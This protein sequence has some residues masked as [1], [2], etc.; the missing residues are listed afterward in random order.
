MKPQQVTLKSKEL[1]SEMASSYLNTKNGN[2]S[3]VDFQGSCYFYKELCP[4][5][6]FHILKSPSLKMADITYNDLL[7]FRDVLI[8]LPRR[9]IQ[10]YKC[11]K[12]NALMKNSDSIPSKDR[13]SANTVNKYIQRLRAL[14][15][16]A[17]NLGIINNNLAKSLKLVATDVDKLQRLPLTQEEISTLLSSVSQ[18][19]RYLLQVLTLTGM[20]LSELYKCEVEELEG[21]KCFSLLNRDIKLK[22]KSSYRVIPVHRGLLNRLEDFEH[23][24]NQVSSDNLAKTT[25]ATIKRLNFKR[26]E[27]KFLYSLRHTFATELIQAGADTSIVSEL[28]GHYHSTMTLSRYSTGFSIEQLKKVVEMNI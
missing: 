5:I 14:F 15:G 26:K 10:K 17:L 27:K 16:F 19:M 23:S 28:L 1:Y 18:K 13:V 4:S 21:T 2:V 24:R 6:F 3:I 20:R 11:I 22:T 25:S 12:L 7:K 8:L 9:N